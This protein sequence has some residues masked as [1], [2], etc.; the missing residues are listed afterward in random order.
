MERAE[1]LHPDTD[2]LPTDAAHQ[3]YTGHTPP[4][5]VQWLR[6]GVVLSILA[7]MA[8][9]LQGYWWLSSPAIA[10]TETV[11]LTIPRGAT[12]AQVR[13]TLAARGW[14][15]NPRAFAL[16][17]RLL[18]YPESVKP[19][20]YALSPDQ[21][22]RALIEMLRSGDQV[23]VRVT[24]IACR[25]PV[26]LARQ[27]CRDL[28]LTDS[29]LVEAL[30]DTSLLGPLGFAP[31]TALALFI[32]NTYELWWHS[33]AKTVVNRMGAEYKRFWNDTR[34]AQAQAQGLS[35]LEVAVLASIIDGETSKADEMPT[36]AG[37]YL[38]RL[39]Q[40]WPLQADPT[41][42]YAVGDWSLRR[43]LLKH[44]QVESPYNT[45]RVRGLPPGPISCPSQQAIR[46]VL[47]PEKHNYMYFCARHTLDGYHAF[48]TTLSEHNA[49]AARYH[50]AINARGIR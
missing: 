15:H 34:R 3:P 42:K 33:S 20:R 37:V 45:Y 35:P 41:V 48:A 4:R 38:N 30:Q 43:V 26:D 12:Y 13:D 25:T 39:R 5:W 6:M 32:P 27:V 9:A 31:H 49:N 46:A 23:P 28:E 47:S 11:Y 22:H 21:P 7:G 36:I 8:L 1:P 29:T 24:F 17:A 44:T 10:T 19:G 14:L 16:S 50:A 40:G 18:S 2:T